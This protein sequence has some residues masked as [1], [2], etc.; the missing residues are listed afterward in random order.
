METIGFEHFLTNEIRMPLQALAAYGGMA[1]TTI[2]A[3][4]LEDQL[5]LSSHV[6]MSIVGRRL[7][8]MVDAYAT[9]SKAQ[10]QLAEVPGGM[11]AFRQ[12]LALSRSES[13]VYKFYVGVCLDLA[14]AVEQ[15]ASLPA[16]PKL[17]PGEASAAKSFVAEVVPDGGMQS[18][19]VAGEKVIGEGNPKKELQWRL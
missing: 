4:K 5:N 2:R 1:P 7:P 8:A 19:S 16:A 18:S 9:V 14:K 12:T 17:A 10:D 6:L 11:A 15:N 3:K 13:Y